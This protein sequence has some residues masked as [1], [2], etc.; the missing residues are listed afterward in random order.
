MLS[1]SLSF[2][3]V[4]IISL[5]AAP[6]LGSCYPSHQ[7]TPPAPAPPA[8][9]SGRDTRLFVV[10]NGLELHLYNRSR[11]YSRLERLFGLEPLLLGPDGDGGDPEEPPDKGG[12]GDAS[13]A[14][15]D[16]DLAA[17]DPYR[18]WRDLVPV[19]KA[20]ISTVRNAVE[21]LGAAENVGPLYLSPLFYKRW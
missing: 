12:G 21:G 10:L 1:I 9:L 15:T 5:T 3:V 19:I 6:I 2:I 7:F 4:T 16:A 14:P 18:G 8:D 13:P 17:V 20:D 11:L